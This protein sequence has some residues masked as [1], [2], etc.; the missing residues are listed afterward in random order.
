MATTYEICIANANAGLESWTNIDTLGITDPWLQTMVAGVD[1]LTFQVKGATAFTDDTLFAYRSLVRFRRVTDGVP[2]L[3]FLG[4]TQPHERVC[5][6]SESYT[7][8]L[9]GMWDWFDDTPMRQEWTENGSVISKPRVILFCSAT[10]TRV[11]TGAQIEQ[12]VLAAIEAG[13]PCAEPVAGDIASGFMP[14]FDEQVNISVANAVCKAL[15]NHPHASCWFDYSV[16]SPRLYVRTRQSLPAVNVSISGKTGIRVKSR[17]DLQP[18]AVTICYEKENTVDGKTFKQT[19]FDYQ[20]IVA[21]ETDAQRRDRL[22]QSGAV[23]GVYDLQG[24]QQQSTSQ[25]IEVEELPASLLDKA[26]W[27]SK[28][29]RLSDYAES[30]ITLTNAQRGGSLPSILKKGS[31]QKWMHVDSERETITVQASLVNRTGGQLVEDRRETLSVEL[32]MTDAVTKTYKTVTSFDSGESIPNGVAAEMWAEWSQLHHE[33]GVSQVEV[34]PSLNLT[35]G[36]TLNLTGGRTEWVSMAAMIVR[37]TVTFASGETSVETG[38]PGW[39]DLDSRVAWYRACRNRRYSFS[40]QMRES[41]TDDE[42]SGGIDD[43]ASTRDAGNVCEIVRRRFFDPTATTKHEIDLFAQAAAGGFEFAGA[44]AATNSATA[45]VIRPREV[46]MPYVKTDG[47]VAAKLSQCLC[48]DGYGTEKPLGGARPAD[49]TNPTTIGA[50]EEGT[51]S[52]YTTTYDGAAAN[53]PGLIVWLLSRE[54]FFESGDKKLYCY[55]RSLTFP[56]AIAPTVSAETRV[57]V[58]TPQV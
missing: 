8:E 31:I 12:C 7:V 48:S 51:E 36:K 15:A 50:G 32:T 53:A 17:E 23:W 26:W 56:A 57:L 27:K 21:G 28:V 16:R 42:S 49:P 2:A 4:R 5:D 45:R 47:T 1:T 35:V 6:P 52:A 25:D 19:T 29:P 14:P 46:L 39:I 34:E 9:R 41:E 11:T 22:A 37:C 40:R 58:D 30:D 3:L 24:S 55:M 33:C 54:G 38:V 20:P 43:V 18:T 10:G 44:E 13:C